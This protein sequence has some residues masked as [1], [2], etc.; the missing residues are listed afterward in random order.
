M[1]IF[2]VSFA[3]SSLIS[4]LNLP[5]KVSS[6]YSHSWTVIV[7]SLHTFLTFWVVSILRVS[8][9][10]RFF[11]IVGYS[12]AIIGT[13]LIQLEHHL[14]WTVW[15]LEVGLV[16]SW[17]FIGVKIYWLSVL[18]KIYCIGSISPIFDSVLTSVIFFTNYFQIIFIHSIYSIINTSE[19]NRG[20][21]FIFY[22]NSIIIKVAK[23]TTISNSK[24]FH[25]KGW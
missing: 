7:I 10:I 6:M 24:F 14:P 4:L 9:T 1:Q 25:Y 18:I 20:F 8:W 17:L 13:E 3:Q 21:S 2:R 5:I 22:P 19:Y 16:F 23:Q 12:L 11:L 15:V